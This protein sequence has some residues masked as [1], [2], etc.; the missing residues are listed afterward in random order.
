MTLYYSVK[1]DVGRMWKDSE[2]EVDYLD[3][4]YLVH[5]LT[6]IIKNDALLPASIGIYGDWGSGKSSLMHMCISKLNKND[7]T[8]CILFNGWLFESYADAKSALLTNILDA[9]QKERTSREKVKTIL[10]GLYKSIDKLSF[11]EKALRYGFGTAASIATGGAALVPLTVEMAYDA[12]N[13][14]NGK[15]IKQN[16]SDAWTY[17]ELRDDLRTFRDQFAELLEMSKI[18]R[19]AIFIDELDRCR[20]DTILDTLEAMRLFMFTG[21]VAFIIGADER[22]IS[23]AVKSK[24]KNIEGIQIDIGKEYLE[25]LVQYPIRIPRMGIAETEIYITLLLLSKELPED[26]FKNVKIDVDRKRKENLLKSPFPDIDIKHV[27]PEDGEYINKYKECVAIGEQLAAVLSPGLHGN[28]R[29][30]KRFL[31]MLDMRIKMA[32]YKGKDLDRKV[33][34]KIMVLEYIRSA[35]FNKLAEMAFEGTLANEL[36]LLEDKKQNNKSVLHEWLKDDWLKEWLK[37][38]PSLKGQDLADYFYFTRTSLDEKISRVSTQLSPEGQEILDKLLSGADINIKQALNR[39]VSDA[40]A[41]KILEAFGIQMQKQTEISREIMKAFIDFS[42]KN[43]KRY[44]KAFSILEQLPV[45]SLSMSVMP[46]IQEF[47][48]KTSYKEDVATL[49]EKWGKKNPKLRKAF[50]GASNAQ[51]M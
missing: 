8:K 7:K 46:S 31:N 32:K 45:S 35:A 2:T 12:T 40:E 26:I 13:N 29:Q 18:D 21:K 42:L 43:Q 6:E 36:E 25:K 51:E 33:L 14:V 50:H 30:V 44:S 47:A 48:S 11:A 1:G 20:E 41:A 39:A 24:F 5:I 37:I 49:V 16:I 19:L 15:E 23:Y 27:C 38:S 10:K 34:A 28:P 22:H 3:Y 4:G 9:F 17:K